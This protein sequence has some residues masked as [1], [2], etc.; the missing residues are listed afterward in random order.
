M[1]IQHALSLGFDL[2]H[3]YVDTVG[4]PAAHSAKLSARFPG[5]QFTVCSKADSIYPIVGAASI[6]AKVTRDALVEG[7]THVESRR[8]WSGALGSG[9]PSDP[10]TVAW[11]EETFDPVFGFPS[12][13]RFSWGT[14]RN[15]FEKRGAKSRWTDE[16]KNLQKWFSEEDKR[17]REEEKGMQGV[18]KELGVRTVAVL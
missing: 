4:P 18:W 8:Q 3:I 10:N 17:R 9:Y 14:V 12:I 13:A 1:L 6:G 2:R 16:P 7:W 5:I 11:L 15:M